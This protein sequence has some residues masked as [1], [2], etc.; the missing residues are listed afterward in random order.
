MMTLVQVKKTLSRPWVRYESSTAPWWPQRAFSFE[1][2][3]ALDSLFCIRINWRLTGA[4][5]AQITTRETIAL[6][7]AVCHSNQQHRTVLATTCPK[8]FGPQVAD[9][10]IFSNLARFRPRCCFINLRLK[11]QSDRIGP[12]RWL[13]ERFE[14]YRLV[15]NKLKFV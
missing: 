10:L 11:F 2:F 15:P 1:L 8:H 9:R 7:P 13:I 4:P 6:F 14:S 5:T 12:K 3:I